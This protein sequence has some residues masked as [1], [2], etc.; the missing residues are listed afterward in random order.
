MAEK[1]FAQPSSA[2]GQS[3]FAKAPSAEIQRSTFDRSHGH[4]TTFN[5]GLLYP[6]YVDEVLPGDSFKLNSTAFTRLS[7]PLK[8]IMDNMVVD[9]HYFFVP[10]RLVWDNSEAFFSGKQTTAAVAPGDDTVYSVPQTAIQADA[11]GEF[12][13]SRYMGIPLTTATITK[14]VSALPFR[15]YGLIWNEW[16]RDQNLQEPGIV[17]T[18]DGPD[19]YNNQTVLQRN[20]RHDYFTSALPWPQKGDPVVIPLG[21]AAPIY[22][23]SVAPTWRQVSGGTTQRNLWT[24]SGTNNVAIDGPQPSGGPIMFGTETGLFTDLTAAT[25]TSIN[26]LRTAFQIQRLLERDAR[27][28]TRYVESILS[29]FG[30]TSDDARLNRPEYL[31][32]GSNAIN[33]NPIA[34]TAALEVAPQAT[35]AA[36]GTAVGKAGFNKSF[37]EHGIIIG[38]IS[39]RAD[40]TY[41][42]GLERFWSRQTRY[43][44]YWP[45]LAHLGEQEI[46]TQEIYL[47]GNQNTNKATWG[48]QERYAEYRYKPSRISGK[49]QSNDAASLD[50]W[51]LAQAFTVVP[52][53]NASFIKENPPIER[54]VAVTSEPHFLCDIWFSLKCSRPMPVYSVPGLID[55]F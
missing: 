50:V 45:A 20:K 36:T 9:T 32:G 48:Y 13:L 6:I 23:K 44:F 27:G 41:Q 49:F 22:S 33:I 17:D 2:P 19:S 4:K 38:L 51:H 42:N 11:Q 46:K 37:T 5:A 43:D 25:A 54:I 18:N 52:E 7:T 3:H 15:A 10:Y 29:H 30:V 8:P 21:D 55:H 31:G 39:V 28:G 26:D 24:E 53:L 40:L 16:Y 12:A 47:A 35:L 1:Y 34:S 14:S